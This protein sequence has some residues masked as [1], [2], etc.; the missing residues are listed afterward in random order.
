MNG[1][2]RASSMMKHAFKN[3]EP[4]E[5][6]MSITTIRAPRSRAVP[7]EDTYRR[8]SDMEKF[9]VRHS[10]IKGDGMFAPLSFVCF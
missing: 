9:E 8:V 2:D 10:M 5:N 6:G 7:T 4:D 3:V 1:S